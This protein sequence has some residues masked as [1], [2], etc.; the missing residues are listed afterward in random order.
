MY[1]Q[2][3][4]ISGF[5]EFFFGNCLVWFIS[6]YNGAN[7]STDRADSRSRYPAIFCGF[8]CAWLQILSLENTE[9]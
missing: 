9:T 4:A 1:F 2:S 6:K 8:D 7:P 5:T 3:Q